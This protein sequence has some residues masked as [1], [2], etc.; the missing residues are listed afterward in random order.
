M[1]GS[2]LGGRRTTRSARSSSRTADARTPTTTSS[3]RPVVCRVTASRSSGLEATWRSACPVSSL[4]STLSVSSRVRGL[5]SAAVTRRSSSP[6]AASSAA[7]RSSTR[8]RTSERAISSGSEPASARSMT[9]AISGADRTSS[10]ASSSGP[11]QARAAARA[12]KNAARPAVWAKLERSR[13]S[14]GSM[15]PL[16][17]VVRRPRRSRSDGTPAGGRCA[18]RWSAFFPLFQPLFLPLLLHLRGLLLRADVRRLDERRAAAP[19]EDHADEDDGEADVERGRDELLAHGVRGRRGRVRVAVEGER[20]ERL[21]DADAARREREQV[22]EL[23]R[24]EHA[25]DRAEAHR[26][27]VRREKD[28]DHSDLGHVATHLRKQHELHVRAEVAEDR[29][30]FLGPHPHHFDPVPED[31]HEDRDEEDRAGDDPEGEHGMV[32]DRIPLIAE[33]ELE[34]AGDLGEEVEVDEGPDDHVEDLLDHV[35]GEDSR[36]RRP[37]DD[38]DVHDERHERAHVRGD[39]VV[40]RNAGRVR[41]EHG[42]VRHTAGVRIAQDPVPAECGQQ[43]LGALE[44]AAQN[45]VAERDVGDRVPQALQPTPDVDAD[46]LQNEEDDEDPYEPGGDPQD[47]PPRMLTRGRRAELDGGIGHPR[48]PNVPSSL[49]RHGDAQSLLG[50]DQVIR[51]LGG[52]VDVELHPAHTP[53]ELAVLLPVVVA[54]RRRGV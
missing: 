43:G 30:A 31:P 19:A 34:R 52:S 48:E 25:H 27:P 51:V 41:G 12:G 53:G 11:R 4:A 23:I 38:R 29:G 45:H 16:S 7:M 20:V 40:Q 2:A 32:G 49:T 46:R 33:L 22:R 5:A 14:F 13:S 18:S 1:G 24:S 9:R 37:A 3:A 15:A 36:E 21:V 10:T 39:D 42:H 6:L 35:A 8:F 17:P 26:N 44:E 47:A 28:D 50:A 54:D